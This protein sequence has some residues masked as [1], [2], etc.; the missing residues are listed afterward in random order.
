MQFLP[1]QN[2]DCGQCTKCCRG[3]RVGVDAASRQRLEDFAGKAAIEL[4]Q[5]RPILRRQADGSCGQLDANGLCT[6]HQIKPDGCRQFPF[7]LCRTPEGVSVGVSFY[8]SSVQENSG[9]RLSAHQAELEQLAADLPILGNQPLLVWDKSKPISMPWQSY[10]LL[11]AFLWD[12]LEIDDPRERLARSLWAVI[13]CLR[14]GRSSIEPEQLQSALAASLGPCSPPNE[15]FEWRLRTLAYQVIAQTDDLSLSALEGDQRISW[16]NWQG[17]TSD[18]SSSKG[19]QALLVRYLR[20]LVF[21]KF[22]IQRR[23]ILTNLAAL[24]LAPTLWG[25][26]S[27]PGIGPAGYAIDQCERRV[28]T[29]SNSLDPVLDHLAEELMKII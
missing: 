22:L 26:W 17:R 16:G 6:A 4:Y 14:Q 11:D 3:W 19:D 27:N 9:R 10:R 12:G 24:N 1:G 23:S 8:C 25:L 29:H 18:L 13:F 7:R 21:R 2:F 28:F 15:P 5:G 20:A